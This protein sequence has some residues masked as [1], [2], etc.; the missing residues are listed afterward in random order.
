MY[1]F[2]NSRSDFLLLLVIWNY[3]GGF[4]W[5]KDV[6]AGWGCSTSKLM[7]KELCFGK[8][9]SFFGDVAPFSAVIF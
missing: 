4:V 7:L 1:Q 8:C 3:Q 5:C 6:G 2:S 9:E